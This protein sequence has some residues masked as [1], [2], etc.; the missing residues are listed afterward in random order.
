ML[1][2]LILLAQEQARPTP[3]PWWY[4]LLPFVFIAFMLYLF[5]LRPAQRQEQQRKALLAS[6]KKNDRVLTTGGIYGTV[7]AISD[8]DDEVT[9]KVDD[10]CRLKMV[11]SSIARNLTNE[12]AARAAKAPPETRA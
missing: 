6:I 4:E 11:K 3:A 10:N 2:T 8:K 9:V 12:E 5:L 7:V 1:A